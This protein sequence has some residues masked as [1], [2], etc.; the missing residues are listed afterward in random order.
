MIKDLKKI[1]IEKEVPLWK[2]IAAELEGSTSKRRI[3]NLSKIDRYAKK[4]EVVIVPGKVLAMGELNKK[5]TIVA[6]NYSHSALEKIRESGSTAMT[7]RQLM[8]KNPK[9]KKVRIIG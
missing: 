8:D 4:D 5:V 3:V 1:S 6:Y 2:R 7:I 9:G